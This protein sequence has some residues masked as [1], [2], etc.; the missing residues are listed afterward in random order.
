MNLIIP[1]LNNGR[2]RSG[3][4]GR[5]SNRRNETDIVNNPSTVDMLANEVLYLEDAYLGRAT[6]ILECRVD[7]QEAECQRLG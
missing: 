5:N 3:D 6:A 2:V 4:P 7:H 1:G